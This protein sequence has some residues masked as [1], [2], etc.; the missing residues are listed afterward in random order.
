MARPRTAT[1]ILDARGAFQKDPQRKRPNEPK[2]T[3]AFRASAPAHL[4]AE[5]CAVWAELVT[6]IPAGVL[7][8]SDAAVVEI[9]AVL[10]AQFR[11]L[12]ADMPAGHLTRMCALMGQLGLSPSG[13]AS[14]VVP[15]EK[16]NPFD[17]V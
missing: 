10:F 12:G 8:G 4:T 2:S 14:L 5:Q 17:D 16:V 7:T 13:R 11:E 6:Q 3:I 15:V 9:T 1:N